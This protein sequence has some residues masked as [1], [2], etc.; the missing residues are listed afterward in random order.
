LGPEFSFGK[1]SPRIHLFASGILTYALGCVGNK[2]EPT[3]KGGFQMKSAMAKSVLSGLCV[4]FLGGVGYGEAGPEIVGV[5]EDWE[6]LLGE[7]DTIKCSPQILTWMSPTQTLDNE[8]FGID[9]NLVQRPDFSS[10]GF[11]TRAF[12]GEAL[13]DSSFSEN[14]DKL[15][16][17]GETIRWTQRMFLSSQQLYF[18]V[19][20]GLSQSWG[21]FGGS[22]TRVRFPTTAL[23]NLNNYNPNCS[24]EWSGVGFGANRVDYLRLKAIRLYTADGQVFTV[25]LNLE[26]D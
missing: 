23:L 15:S 10:G 1:I 7:P 3:L 22:A 26:V 19:A 11:Q 4:I 12:D 8:H 9:L 25:P 18:E 2:A 20:N 6:M 16:H 5:E 17:T 13:V 21:A 14:G 24:V